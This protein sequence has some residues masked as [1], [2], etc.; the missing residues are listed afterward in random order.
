MQKVSQATLVLFHK[1]SNR[2]V[3]KNWF[4]YASIKLSHLFTFLLAVATCARQAPIFLYGV[5]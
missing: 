4:K 1:K 5:N 3:E 2:N